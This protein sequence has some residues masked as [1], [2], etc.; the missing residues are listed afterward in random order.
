MKD[1][2][3]K[4]VFI[5]GL[6]A[7]FSM[8]ALI[9]I[10]TWFKYQLNPDATAYISI[11][12]KYAHG[13]FRHAING[14]WGPMLSWL[15][16]PSIW[17]D[18]P[19]IIAAKCV[20]VAASVGILI[21]IYA[22]LLQRKVGRIVIYTVTASLAATML[23][24]T[25]VEAITP[26]LL[27]TF[28]VTLLAVVLANFLAKP[29]R[30][31]GL[32][33]GGIGAAMYFTKGFGFFLFI[34]TVG[35][36]ALYYWLRV[37][38]NFRVVMKRYL[39]VAAMFA[40]LVVPFIAVISVKYHGP[41]INNAGSFNRHIHGFYGAKTTNDPPLINTAGPLKPT[42]DTA[43]NIWEDPTALTPLVPGWT[44]FDSRETMYYFI[45]GTIG[46]NL[47]QALRTVYSQGPL[48][49]LG[50][51]ALVLGCLQRKHFQRE[52]L[53]F[54]FIVTLMVLGYALVL[55]E[56]RYLWASITVGSMALALFAGFLQKK[57]VISTLQIV[58][59]GLI[60]IGMNSLATGQVIANARDSG[61]EWLLMSK[62][63]QNDLPRGAHIMSDD[64]A[65]SYHMC[66]YLDLKCY[67]V[68]SPPTGDQT[69][70]YMLLKKYHVTYILD[71]HTRPDEIVLKQFTNNYLAKIAERTSGN[72]SVTI[73]Q[74]K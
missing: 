6:C 1:F 8:A 45:F 69:E 27:F 65:R 53:V 44:P 21:T 3:K 43:I 59:V 68:L 20:A 11:A 9:L 54:T 14:Y 33:L 72:N 30:N 49:V 62:V 24:W 16:V 18:M 13:D 51:G 57:R 52:Y 47:N 67:N 39:P 19:P 66:F 40:I 25:T 70:Y 35:L 71:F 34:G 50:L 61:R 41:T 55:T 46:K 12:E 26:D 63:L 64:F 22:A 56:G 31:L 15:L 36:I 48:I 28:L 37:D 74:V 17:L 42:N 73:Y 60:V 4:H 58:V 23:I 29:T 32:L 5:I 2:L 38:K 10:C 7:L